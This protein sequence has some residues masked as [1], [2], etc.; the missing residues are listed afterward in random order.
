MIFNTINETTGSK[1]ESDLGLPANITIS[2]ILLSMS[3]FYGYTWLKLFELYKE[4][5]QMK[6]EKNPEDPASTSVLTSSK[7]QVQFPRI[8]SRSQLI[9]PHVANAE[10]LKVT[11]QF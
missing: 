8:P 3:A 2:A 7:S 9:L 11:Q 6:V 5:D 4:L 10:N 1:T